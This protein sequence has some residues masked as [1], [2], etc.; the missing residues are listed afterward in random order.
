VNIPGFGKLD[1][2]KGGIKLTKDGKDEIL[3]I[4]FGTSRGGKWS[5][6][7]NPQ[8]KIVSR[9]IVQLEKGGFEGALR[10]GQATK[11]RKQTLVQ[12]QLTC[13]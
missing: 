12:S 1:G 4:T 2:E 8:S 5:V 7:I 3:R 11:Q 13:W 10:E 9:E 6:D